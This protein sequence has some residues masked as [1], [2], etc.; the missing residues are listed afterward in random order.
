MKTILGRPMTDVEILQA[1]IKKAKKNNFKIDDETEDY[2]VTELADN[3]PRE[4]WETSGNYRDLIFS[5][6]FARAFFG[7]QKIKKHI[8]GW[9]TIE[10]WKY[11]IQQMVLENNP[12]TYLQ[13]FL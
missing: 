2:Y 5:H 10:S 1:S 13:K 4:S 12:L 8:G 11:H 3:V 9:I 6:E 7:T